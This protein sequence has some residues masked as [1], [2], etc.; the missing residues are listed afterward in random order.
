MKLH[1]NYIIVPQHSY[2]CTFVLY[3]DFPLNKWATVCAQTWM[4]FWLMVDHRVECG[5]FLLAVRLLLR[6]LS[7][8]SFQW[9]Q[10]L[11]AHKAIVLSLCPCCN[12]QRE[13]LEEPPTG[14]LSFPLSSIVP[15]LFPLLGSIER[16]ITSVSSCYPGS[17]IYVS[18]VQ[19]NSSLHL[20]QYTFSFNQN[21][22]SSTQRGSHKHTYART[23]LDPTSLNHPI[24]GSGRWCVQ[25][26]GT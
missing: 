19:T 3:I 23:L 1:S 22:S 14:L 24:G 6:G 18:S 13:I 4:Y 5:M 11:W 16:D 15:L 2:M 10:S 7:V 17:L 12:H 21:L 9:S 26:S 8:N 20:S 25:R